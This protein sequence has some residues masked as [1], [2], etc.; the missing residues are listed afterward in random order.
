[1]G[2]RFDSIGKRLG[3][4]ALAFLSCQP[5]RR[6]KL[7]STV[8]G[9]DY[10]LPWLDLGAHQHPGPRVVVG[11][12]LASPASRRQQTGRTPRGDGDTYH[13]RMVARELLNS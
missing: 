12:P 11:L 10:T 3:T 8:T 2:C 7:T 5:A 4:P 9:G 13:Q 6:A 1:M